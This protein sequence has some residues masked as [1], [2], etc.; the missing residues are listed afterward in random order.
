MELFILKAGLLEQPFHLDYARFHYLATD[1]WIKSI[2][3]K[4][5]RF[6]FQLSLGNVVCHPPRRG[7]GWL[8]GLFC[9]LWFTTTELTR[10]NRARIHQQVLFVSDVMDAGGR[11][12][13][14]K[15]LSLRPESEQWSNLFAGGQ[16]GRFARVHRQASRVLA[17]GNPGSLGRRSSCHGQAPD[18]RNGLQVVCI[19]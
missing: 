5:S 19:D 16:F 18:G 3:E 8:M 7:D 6:G 17:V 12:I 1:C 10:L 15:Y 14:N 11:E 13:D 9:T 2:W 4:V